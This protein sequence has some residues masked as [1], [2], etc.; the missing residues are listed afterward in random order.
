IS[1]ARGAVLGQDRLRPRGTDRA[2]LLPVEIRREGQGFSATN[3]EMKAAI[4]TFRPAS[5]RSPS[6]L[7]S[8]GRGEG[9]VPRLRERERVAEGQVRVVGLKIKTMGEVRSLSF[10]ARAI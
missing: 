7:P 9:L 1:R 3:S 2:D 6:P 5:P 4:Q 10:R 8:D